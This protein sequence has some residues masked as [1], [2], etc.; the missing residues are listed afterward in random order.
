MTLKLIVI[1]TFLIMLALNEAFKQDFFFFFPKG[2]VKG[3][4]RK[5]VSPSIASVHTTQLMKVQNMLNF[6]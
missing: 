1:V 3:I 5:K 2:T 6:V 4:I